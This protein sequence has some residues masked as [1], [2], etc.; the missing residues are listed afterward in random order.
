MA[1]KHFLL[2]IKIIFS[3]WTN[4][5]TELLIMQCN[6]NSLLK[7]WTATTFP[8]EQLHAL[9]Q[10]LITNLLACFA[11]RKIAIFW[12]YTISYTPNT[13]PNN[14]RGNA[15]VSGFIPVSSLRELT[16]F[17]FLR[18]RKRICI[19]HSLSQ[20]ILGQILS[21]KHFFFA[22][23]FTSVQISFISSSTLIMSKTCCGYS[24]FALVV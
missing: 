3:G 21:N 17:F 12:E 4:E 9:N 2:S 19:S 20:K 14:A 18:E 1:V 11:L 15:S 8:S 24:L 22:S 16:D 13:V 5:A 23:N 6:Q 10:H 7:K